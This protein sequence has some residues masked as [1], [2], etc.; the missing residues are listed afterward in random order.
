MIV[1]K[2]T[3]IDLIVDEVYKDINDTAKRESLT[4]R[5]PVKTIFNP[6]ATIVMF[7]DGSKIISKCDKEDAF[8]KETGFLMCMLKSIYGNAATH[9][10]LERFIYSV[11]KPT[12]KNIKKNTKTISKVTSVKN[13]RG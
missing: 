5:Y 11:E 13:K 8:S 6:P 1:K 4:R 3:I 9:K 7:N 12:K 2:G 10:M